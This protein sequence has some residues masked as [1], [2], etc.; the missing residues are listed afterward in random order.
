MDQIKQH[1][2]NNTTASLLTSYTWTGYD[3]IGYHTTEDGH[4]KK[5]QQA[6][7]EVTLVQLLQKLLNETFSSF[8][9]FHKNYFCYVII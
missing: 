4:E 2:K 9:K 8:I 6:P 3:V 5:C 7:R 1:P